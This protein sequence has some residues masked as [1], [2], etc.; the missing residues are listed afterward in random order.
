MR[1]WR[2]WQ[3]R[4]FEGHVVHTV[5]V[6]VPFLAP[7]KSRWIFPSALFCYK[8]A[9]SLE[10]VAKPQACAKVLSPVLHPF[11]EPMDFPSALFCF[12]RAVSL[13]SVAKPQACA[14]VLSPVSRT[15]KVV[16]FW[17]DF[18]YSNRRF[19]ISSRFS[20]YLISPLG[21]ISSLVRVYFPAVWWYTMLRIDDIQPLRV[22]WYTLSAKVIKLQAFFVFSRKI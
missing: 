7:E 5:R 12:E 8:K 17:Y 15:K 14:K 22:W 2:N 13:E 11:Q 9:V 6:Q 20:V 16:S 3:T 10:L 4:T 18:F 21:C 1:E 19:G